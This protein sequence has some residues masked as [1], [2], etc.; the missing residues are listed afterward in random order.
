M[1]ESPL[2]AFTNNHEP[3]ATVRAE[4]LKRVWSSVAAMPPQTGICL[5]LIAS[6]CESNADAIAAWF[7]ASLVHQLLILGRLDRWRSGST[8]QDRVFD[9]AASFPFPNGP[10]G[11]DLEAFAAALDQ[12]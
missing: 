6:M 9:V 4:D 12:V 7:R 3:V 2:H 5:D 11:V 1:P 8:L 10:A